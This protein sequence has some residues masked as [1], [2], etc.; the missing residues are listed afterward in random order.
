MPTT[1]PEEPHQNGEMS[2]ENLFDDDDDVDMMLIDDNHDAEQSLDTMT[3]D[4]LP[5][6][7]L[8]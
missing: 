6:F 1:G 7:I 4:P 3:F 2:L 8:N 5:E